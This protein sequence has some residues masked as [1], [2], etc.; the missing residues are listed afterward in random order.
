MIKKTITRP[1][2]WT[3]TSGSQINITAKPNFPLY[4]YQLYLIRIEANLSIEHVLP[5]LPFNSLP[6]AIGIFQVHIFII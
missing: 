1:H 5:Q 2:N 4:L 3:S 6:I